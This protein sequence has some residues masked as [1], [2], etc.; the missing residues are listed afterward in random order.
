MMR[1]YEKMAKT[2]LN[3]Y[4]EVLGNKPQEPKAIETGIVLLIDQVEAVVFVKKYG[5]LFLPDLKYFF[6]QFTKHLHEIELL[7]GAAKR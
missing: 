4:F 6:F 2:H 1:E 5:L 3:R 7:S